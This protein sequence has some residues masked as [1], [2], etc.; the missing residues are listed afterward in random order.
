MNKEQRR[1]LLFVVIIL[2]LLVVVM[3]SGL[4]I[5]ES[6]ISPGGEERL[7]TQSKAIYRDGVKY[8]PRKDITTLLLLGI[9]QSGKVTP[10]EYN[11]SIPA[12]M[13][14]LMVFDEQT[15]QYHII[16]INRDLMVTMPALNER[17][18]ETGTYYGQ[19]ALSHTY[20]DGMED[21]CENVR[22]TVSSL[23]YGLDIDYYLSLNMDTISIINDAL[24]GVKV[25]VVDDFSAVDPDL[26][27][28]E[29]VLKG[30]QAV[31]YLQTRWAVG[32]ELNLSRMERQQTYMRSF[33]PALK[34]K[35]EAD[36]KFV[37]STFNKIINYIVTD[38]SVETLS[39]LET[40]YGGYS[41]GQI[42]T[43]DGENVLGENLYEFYAD[44]EAL[45]ALILRLFYVAG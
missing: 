2:I 17:G 43:I 45:D 23:F 28:G 15:Q 27:M 35:M 34:E 18:W 38:C 5:L 1:K 24:G 9:N 21:S 44:E 29:V 4:Q 7:Q 8:Y 32:D 16:N 30:Q 41:V 10:T 37:L 12:D 39:R 3:Y 14:M 26:P 31:T 19:I 20:G 11:R 42:L 33:T 36:S 22:K 25:T 6:A 40:E 13:L